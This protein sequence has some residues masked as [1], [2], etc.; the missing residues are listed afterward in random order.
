MLLLFT[1]TVTVTVC[2]IERISLILRLEVLGY[3]V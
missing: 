1:I 3:I 2:I